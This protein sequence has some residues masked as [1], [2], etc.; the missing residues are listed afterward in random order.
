MNA[1]DYACQELLI[2]W[3]TFSRSGLRFDAQAGEA[4]VFTLEFVEVAH[5]E[6][7]TATKR[8]WVARLREIG[9]AEAG[10]GLA[11]LRAAPR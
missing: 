3:G 9:F 2:A 6:L 7:G 1:N 11:K 4:R 10:P 8:N 5:E